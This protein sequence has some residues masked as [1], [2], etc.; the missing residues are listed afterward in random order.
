MIRPDHFGFNPQTAL[1]NVFQHQPTDSKEHIRIN[2][3]KEFDIMV[4]KLRD[5]DLRIVTLPSRN[6]VLTPDAVFPNNWFSHHEKNVLVLYP[7][8]AQNRRNE[9]QKDALLKLL[10]DNNI[11]KPEVLDITP[12]EDSEEILEGTGSI[13]LDREHTVAYAMESP[14]TTQTAFEKWCTKMGYTN[15]F[16][17]AYDAKKVP[18]YHTNVL[19]SIGEKFA[20]VCLEAI[21]SQ[22][23]QEQVR[24]SFLATD[25]TL[26]EISLKQVFQFCGNIL[27]VRSRKEK[28]YI[29]MSETAHKSFDEPQKAI[30][31]QFGELIIVSIPTIE[32]VGGGSARCMLAEIF[33]Y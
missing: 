19:M 7:M 16:F 23:E 31:K 2:A 22:K 21:E 33:T 17:H 29:I 5:Y 25:K 32:K 12:W 20:V 27:N 13:V 1:T 6:D 9:R 30:L 4:N 26:L 3:L 14:R 18:I 10:T 11:Q 24:Q 15:I 28:Q 8:L